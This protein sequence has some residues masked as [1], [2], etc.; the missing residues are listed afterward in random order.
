MIILFFNDA[1]RKR[2]SQN[3]LF[4]N[5]QNPK[6][7][8]IV[9]GLS[10]ISSDLTDIRMDFTPLFMGPFRPQGWEKKGC[11]WRRTYALMAHS[12]WRR[13]KKCLLKSWYKKSHPSNNFT[14]EIFF[15]HTSGQLCKMLFSLTYKLTLRLSEA[16]FEECT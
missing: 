11:T 2:A 10:L 5:V 4:W 3:T 9:S 15:K 7:I 14:T 1:S 12:L 6:N 16:I 8:L 13:E